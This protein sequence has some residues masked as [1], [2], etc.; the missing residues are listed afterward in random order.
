MEQKTREKSRHLS[1]YQ[2]FEALQVEYLIADL[3]FR[4]ATKAKDKEYWKKV[5]DGKKQ[6]IEAIADRN[7]LPTVFT[8]SDLKAELERRIYG[9]GSYPNFHYRDESSKQLQGYWD[10]IH[11]YKPGTEVRFEWFS[12]VKVGRIK[13][14]K[15]N[16]TTVSIEIGEEVLEVEIGAVSRIL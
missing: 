2:Y 11:Y 7:Q 14:Y 12:E 4:I 13:N 16:H 8:D 5:K 6:N 15:P 3:R 10:L 9:C 1:I